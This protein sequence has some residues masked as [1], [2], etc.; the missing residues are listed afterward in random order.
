MTLNY[1]TAEILHVNDGKGTERVAFSDDKA[2]SLHSSRS[3]APG[4]ARSARTRRDV[5]RSR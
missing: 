3:S 4:A 1:R 5:R 2:A